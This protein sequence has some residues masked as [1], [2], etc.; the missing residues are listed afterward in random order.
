VCVCVHVRSCT[1]QWPWAFAVWLCC[2]VAVARLPST[3]DSRLDR[4]LLLQLGWVEPADQLVLLTGFRRTDAAAATNSRFRALLLKY[5]PDKG[6][7]V[8]RDYPHGLQA[9]MLWRKAYPRLWSAASR[10]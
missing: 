6:Q 1:V 7:A 10:S 8:T 5:H 9:V 4:S 3:G 2:V